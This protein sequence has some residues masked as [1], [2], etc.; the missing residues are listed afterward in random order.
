MKMQ[1]KTVN[2]KISIDYLQIK[3]LKM[4][5]N[6]R[7]P[8]EIVDDKSFKDFFECLGFSI[9]LQI[10]IEKHFYHNK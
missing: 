1:Q 4:I 6:C 5:F 9:N 3:F 10:I 8:G 7:I 2:M